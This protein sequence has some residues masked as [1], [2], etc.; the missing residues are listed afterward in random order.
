M[1]KSSRA[2]IVN[3]SLYYHKQK[4]IMTQ[5]S[6]VQSCFTGYMT[7]EMRNELDLYISI[8]CKVRLIM[9][10]FIRF[11]TML[12]PTNRKR[13]PS[14]TRISAKIFSGSTIVEASND[15]S[16]YTA[17]STAAE[18]H[19][20]NKLKKKSGYYSSMKRNNSTLKE[21]DLKLLALQVFQ[22]QQ[23]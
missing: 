1:L 14:N 2:Q 18:S 15:C 9:S 7:Q 22:Q 4:R 3:H 20:E 17:I 12:S 19:K 6:N 10:L 21:S 8:Y 23:A 16:S 13:S 5:Q 11:S